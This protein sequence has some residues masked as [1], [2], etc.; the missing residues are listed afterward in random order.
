[1]SATSTLL[2]EKLRLDKNQGIMISPI[3]FAHNL[4]TYY[5]TNQNFQFV[6]RNGDDIT[7]KFL[8][9][10]DYEFVVTCKQFHHWVQIQMHVRL[11]FRILFRL[12]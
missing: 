1:M 3:Y 8:P 2:L 7:F 10:P 11:T 5:L 6:F 4:V 12:M 9:Q